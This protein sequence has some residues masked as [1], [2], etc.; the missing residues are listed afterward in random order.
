[1]KFLIIQTAFIGDVVLATAMAEALDQLDNAEIHFLVRKGNESLLEN[2]P[3]VDRVWIWNKQQNKLRNL[4]QLGSEIRKEKFDCVVNLQ[5][6]ASTGFLTWR[7]GAAKRIGFE[8]NPFSFCF[9]S[10][11]KHEVNNG[12]HEVNRNLELLREFVPGD[13]PPRLF[14]S[15]KNFEKVAAYKRH[16]FV[17]VAP[18]SVWYTKQ[19]PKENFIQLVSELAKKY[20]VFLLGAKSDFALCEEVIGKNLTK[21]TN[22]CGKLNFLESAALMRDA[23]M[24]FVNDSAPM[25]FASA[26]NAP[27]TA[28][29]CSTIPEFGFGPLSER[30]RV[31]ET[32]EELSCR[33]CGLHGK[34]ACPLG[35]FK[36]GESSVEQIEIL[37]KW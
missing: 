28:F 6:F 22:L 18:S 17:C 23:A 10:K 31:V 1:M 4:F 2:N 8:E 19:W 15:A 32:I 27:T 7:S 33:P 36:C 26:M 25:H 3:F 16:P 34:K 9:S 29:F 24:N 11:F 13:F 12:L 21:S 14:P 35:H 37:T 5:R 30:S 20:H